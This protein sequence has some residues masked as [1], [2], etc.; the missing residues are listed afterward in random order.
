MA[1]ILP[2]PGKSTCKRAV[3]NSGY[4]LCA[5][6]S[7][8]CRQFRH[9]NILEI[10]L[11][12]PSQGRFVDR[13]LRKPLLAALTLAG[14]GPPSSILFSSLLYPIS[15]R[16]HAGRSSEATSEHD[17]PDDHQRRHFVEWRQRRCMH[18]VELR[19]DL[20]RAGHGSQIV[21]A[22]ESRQGDL[23]PCARTCSSGCEGRS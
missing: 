21:L 6:R 7:D 13:E 17:A 15:R 22:D 23:T 3:Q 1:K 8:D 5:Y 2:R 11:Q 10:P 18:L 9:R 4:F 16:A 14:E 20:D 12:I 19:D